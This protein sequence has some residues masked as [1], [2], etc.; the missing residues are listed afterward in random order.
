MPELVRTDPL[1]LLSGYDKFGPIF[2]S[3]AKARRQQAA[4]QA[5]LRDTYNRARAADDPRIVAAAVDVRAVSLDVAR[6]DTT[7]AFME[8]TGDRLSDYGLGEES[9]DKVYEISLVN[10]ARRARE[11]IATAQAGQG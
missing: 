8:L 9:A 2:P 4:L 7:A 11:A 3:D 10:A 1:N 6:L 5:E